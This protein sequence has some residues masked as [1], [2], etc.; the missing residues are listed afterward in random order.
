MSPGDEYRIE[1]LR[2]LDND[3][4]VQEL[5]AFLSHLE[6]CADCRAN[7]EAEHAL[8]HL[9]HRSRPLY[10]A[11]AAL[12][13]RVSEAVIQHSESPARVGF[14]QGALQKLH[15]DLA[16]PIQPVLCLRSLAL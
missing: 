5:N 10:S 7:V 11:P 13:S 15:S 8:S 1:I 14:H 4:Q 2:Y 16:D 12:R 3:L 9:L 6:A